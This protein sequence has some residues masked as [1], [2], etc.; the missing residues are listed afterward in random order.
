MGNWLYHGKDKK[1][2]YN[3]PSCLVCVVKTVISLLRI[4]NSYKSALKNKNR[5]WKLFFA[6]WL[7]FGLTLGFISLLFLSKLTITERLIL[8]FM[9]WGSAYFAVI[10]LTDIYQEEFEEYYSSR[11][12]G[13]S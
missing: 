4:T 3:E 7:I 1:Q 13:E 2:C 6:F 5:L 9:N 12:K 8:A 10:A 11:Q